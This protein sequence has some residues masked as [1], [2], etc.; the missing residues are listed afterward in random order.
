M[1]MKDIEKLRAYAIA[2]DTTDK[3]VVLKEDKLGRYITYAFKDGNPHDCRCLSWYDSLQPNALRR[4][5]HKVEEWKLHEVDG[6]YY[7]HEMSCGNSGKEGDEHCSPGHP[8][9]RCLYDGWLKNGK[10]SY[11]EP[12]KCACWL[13]EPIDDEYVYKQ[14]LTVDQAVKFTEVYCN[15]QI[16]K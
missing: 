16:I 7:L 2:T 12:V 8:C 9:A 10:W 6:L 11:N 14:K 1:N 3:Y 5:G 4:N 13:L 15:T